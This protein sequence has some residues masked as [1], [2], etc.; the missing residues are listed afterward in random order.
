[1]RCLTLSLFW[2]TKGIGLVWLGVTGPENL[3]YW[4][5]WPGYRSL[6]K[7]VYL[8]LPGWK[9]GICHRRKCMQKVRPCGK[10]RKQRLMM[11]W[12]CRQNWSVCIGNWASVQ[13]TSRIVTWRWLINWTWRPR[14]CICEGRIIWTVKLRSCWKDWDFDKKIW[15]GGARNLVG[16]GVCESSWLKYYWHVPM[17]F[18][19]TSRQIIWI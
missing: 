3:H 5:Y 14:C 10:R 2:W 15:N 13:T 9:S 12:I 7:E 17:F 18:Y 19:W 6:P 16:D 11:C 8:F 1:M 4:R